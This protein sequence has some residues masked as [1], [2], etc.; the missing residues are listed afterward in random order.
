MTHAAGTHRLSRPGYSLIQVRGS[1][2]AS[3][4]LV[5]LDV[6]LDG[7][8]VFTALFCPIWILISLGRLLAGRQGLGLATARILI[9]IVTGL[10]VAANYSL[11]KRIATAN[12]TRLIQACERYQQ[13]MGDYP[14]RLND[15][16]PRYLHSVPTA[17]YCIFYSAFGYCGSPPHM[18]FWWDCPPFGR[19]TYTFDTGQWRHQD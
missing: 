2:F 18:L 8:F 7:S 15:L 3:L 12:A 4:V 9:P 5:L 10:M 17:K 13:A 16:V 6:V 11:Q 1:F 14:E 19:R